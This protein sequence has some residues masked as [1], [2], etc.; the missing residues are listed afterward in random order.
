MLSVH[1]DVSV[2][3]FELA[4]VIRQRVEEQFRMLRGHH[5]PGMDPCLW[6]A[7]QDSR[8]IYHKLGL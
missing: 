2:L 8:E 3:V 5:D 7:R 4:D 1:L 6:H